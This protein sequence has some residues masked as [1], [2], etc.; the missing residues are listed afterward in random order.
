MK[1]IKE[2]IDKGEITLDDI[3]EYLN[4]LDKESIDSKELKELEDIVRN[5]PG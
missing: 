2:L 5:H 1:K 3:E 4:S